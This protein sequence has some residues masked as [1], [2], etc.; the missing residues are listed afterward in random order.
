MYVADFPRTPCT[1]SNLVQ[2]YDNILLATNDLRRSLKLVP[3]VLAFILC[4]S[5]DVCVSRVFYCIFA[6]PW[7][8][9][10]FSILYLLSSLPAAAVPLMIFDSHDPVAAATAE[11][12]LVVI[13]VSFITSTPSREKSNVGGFLFHRAL[14]TKGKPNAE[15]SSV[16]SSSPSKTPSV[17]PS[18]VPST[19]PSGRPSGTFTSTPLFAHFL[20]G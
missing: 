9:S 1:R 19:S 5:S 20:Y 16:L 10:I 18:A 14:Q 7:F 13:G 15:P 3:A 8:A 12:F 17:S 11:V 2:A 4:H 6:R